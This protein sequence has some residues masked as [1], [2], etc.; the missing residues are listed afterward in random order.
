M[1]FPLIQTRNP[2]FLQARLRFRLAPQPAK[3]I[4]DPAI[5]AR[6]CAGI[7]GGQHS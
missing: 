2:K 5:I 7:V 3:A 6:N 1:T 4:R